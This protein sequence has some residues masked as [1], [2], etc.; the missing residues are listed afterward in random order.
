MRASRCPE[1]MFPQRRLS[2]PS[3]IFLSSHTLSA[4]DTVEERVE[5]GKGK[6]CRSLTVSARP[7]LA[8]RCTAANRK[9]VMNLEPNA[10]LRSLRILSFSHCEKKRR[11]APAGPAFSFLRTTLPVHCVNMRSMRVYLEVTVSF[12]LVPSVLRSGRRSQEV[13][14]PFLPLCGESFVARPTA[15][16]RLTSSRTSLR[17]FVSFHLLLFL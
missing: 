6:S 16:H 7:G 8:A 5:P 14:K 15:L 12:F 3:V 9:T 2:L 17:V 10:L 13:H 4:T 11:D 1:R